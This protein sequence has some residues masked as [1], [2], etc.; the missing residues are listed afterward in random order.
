MLKHAL[1]LLLL[2]SCTPP[3]PE[4]ASAPETPAAQASP[5]TRD[6]SGPLAWAD[7]AADP[8]LSGQWSGSAYN[9][10]GEPTH[11]AFGGEAGPAAFS[12][13]C[14]GARIVLARHF[15]DVS[16]MA[17][18][19][20]QAITLLAPGGD[21]SFAARPGGYDMPRVVAQAPANDPRLDTLKT[22][23]QGFAVQ[24]AGN[25]ARLPHDDVLARVL[26]ACGA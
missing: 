25:V 14:N 6:A 16:E 4:R 20:T 17:P 26:N 24:T 11:A 7:V 12:I 23:T 10:N 21:H 1:P 9:T 13:T 15:A 22:S 18:E 5:A 19:Q 3:A 2:A 8:H